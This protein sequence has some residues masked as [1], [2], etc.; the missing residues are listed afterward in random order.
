MR[1][2]LACPCLNLRDKNVFCRELFVD[3]TDATGKRVYDKLNGMT[4]HQ[5]RQ[6]TLGKHTSCSCCNSLQV[7]AL[8]ARLLCL[9]YLHSP[10]KYVSCLS[11]YTIVKK[12]SLLETVT[13]HVMNPVRA[14]AGCTLR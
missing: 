12:C 5:C 3:G 13:M 8:A 14:Y 11:I 1:I 2:S 7:S 4:C 6:K 9:P 10:Y